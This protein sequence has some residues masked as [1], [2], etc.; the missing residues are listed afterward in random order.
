MV[1]PFLLDKIEMKNMAYDQ[2]SRI[3]TNRVKMLAFS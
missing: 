2:L 3:L 1:L